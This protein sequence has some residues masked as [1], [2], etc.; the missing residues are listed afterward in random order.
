MHPDNRR[1]QSGRIVL[2]GTDGTKKDISLQAVGAANLS[3]GGYGAFEGFI[4]G[5]WQGESY[6]DGIKLD[7]TDPNIA[8]EL[9][10]NMDCKFKCGNE[11]GYGV[12]ELL[13]VGKYPK[14]GF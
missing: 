3:R 4:H 11:V 5:I 1:L 2:N 14:Y 13:V 8:G 10:W 12:V 6:L 7:L 9:F